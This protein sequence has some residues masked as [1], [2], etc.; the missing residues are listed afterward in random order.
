MTVL[1]DLATVAQKILEKPKFTCFYLEV[2][3]LRGKNWQ[4]VCQ[5]K[6]IKKSMLNNALVANLISGFAR[7][8]SYNMFY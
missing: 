8:I 3:S 5:G 6:N 7:N 2:H 1:D 4:I